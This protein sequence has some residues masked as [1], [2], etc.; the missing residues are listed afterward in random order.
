M[1][2]RS[3]VKRGSGAMRIREVWFQDL[4]VA[5]LRSAEQTDHSE[6][7]IGQALREWNGQ[8]ALK[9]RAFPSSLPAF[10]LSAD[11]P[12]LQVSHMP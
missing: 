4:G 10:Q 11:A 9:L 8:G 7:A 12:R 3:S 2:T 6:E 1:R 5:V